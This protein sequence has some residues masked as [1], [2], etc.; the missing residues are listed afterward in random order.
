M[1]EHER[2]IWTMSSPVS[3]MYKEAMQTF[4]GNEFTTSE[5]HKET[6]NLRLNRDS[7]DRLK[8]AEKLQTS[9]PFSGEAPLHNIITSISAHLQLEQ[10]Q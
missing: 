8:V 3:S 7:K 4:T 1:T 2:A 9:S 10:R 6:T 5:Q